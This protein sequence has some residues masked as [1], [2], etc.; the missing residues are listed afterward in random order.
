MQYVIQC[1]TE[2]AKNIESSSWGH[3]KKQLLC[4][5][6]ITI[7]TIL[8]GNFIDLRYYVAPMDKAQ[9]LIRYNKLSISIATSLM[10][11]HM[12]LLTYICVCV[13][14]VSDLYFNLRTVLT[15][16]QNTVMRVIPFLFFFCH[17]S[18]LR[19]WSM[20]WVIVNCFC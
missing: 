16:W 13:Y 14:L 11:R 5:H 6:P 17:W 8:W 3:N 1:N 9:I 4:N 10:L 2:N 18:T 15:Y 12:V 19:G 20:T 7:G